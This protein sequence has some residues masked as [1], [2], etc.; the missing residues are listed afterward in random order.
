M[1]FFRKDGHDWQKKK[2][3]KTVRET[4]EKLKVGN[5]ELLNC[6]YAHAARDDR[7]QRRCYWLLN[8]DEGVVLVHYLHVT[9][10]AA[11]QEAAAFGQPSGGSGSGSPRVPVPLGPPGAGGVHRV[12]SGGDVS[13]LGAPGSY[14]HQQAGQQSHG[15]APHGFAPH[16]YAPHG[17]FGAHAPYQSHGHL[18]D[19]RH[20]FAGGGSGVSHANVA[21]AAAHQYQR[22]DPWF[23]GALQ[24]RRRGRTKRGVGT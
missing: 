15:F 10:K 8:S 3:G 24:I 9:Q 21:A 19:S 11:M 7:F 5:V 12:R 20:A 6:Y 18:P 2:D 22:D 23:N 14:H 13:S 16:G 1:R 4:H 17:G